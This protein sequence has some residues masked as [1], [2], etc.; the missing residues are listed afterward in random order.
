[1]EAAAN[2]LNEQGVDD[3]KKDNAPIE[4]V[5]KEFVEVDANLMTEQGERLKC[6]R[7][8]VLSTLRCHSDRA[9]WA[10]KVRR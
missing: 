6:S 7:A 10:S 4:E 1:M 9:T 2:I 5:V 8:L 3:G